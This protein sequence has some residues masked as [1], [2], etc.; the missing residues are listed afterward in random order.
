MIAGVVP[1]DPRNANLR[2]PDRKPTL[3]PRALFVSACLVIVAAGL[4][5]AAPVLI[6]F[7]LAAFLV[8]ITQ[9]AVEWL[10]HRRVP[11]PLAISLVVLLTFA[12]LAMFGT[13]LT[14][15]LNEIRLAFPRYITRYQ[16][17]QAT[18]VEAL[19]NRNIGL[20]E[21]FQPDFVNA[22]RLLDFVTGALLELAGFMSATLLV[23]VIAVFG[24]IEATNIPAK[25]TAAFGA[26]VDV[27][28]FAKVAQEVQHYL[29]I[30]TVISL[31]TGLL[32]GVWVWLVGL[33]FAVF[34]GLVAFILNFVPNIGSVLAAIP[35]LMLAI[36]QLG[37]NGTL[38]VAIGYVGV[39]LLLGNVVE[40]TLLGRRLGLSPLVIILSV[41]LWG[42]LWGPIGFL[43]AVPLTMVARI[44]LENT[45]DYRW[46]AVLMAPA[47]QRTTPSPEPRSAS[48]APGGAQDAA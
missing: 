9:P 30:K 19:Q 42:W 35:A 47:S 46:V 34:W 28:R 22:Q 1:T 41:V 48:P 44:M 11:T 45:P 27:T 37:P 10:R 6:L 24:M 14:Q 36:V 40:P 43:L 7:A 26:K 31:A 25:A 8:V 2:M 3:V 21:A 18:F 23:L 5:V 4:K 13:V 17:L 15:S 32:V 16:T 33:D 29:A 39:N 38:F 12:V 20:P